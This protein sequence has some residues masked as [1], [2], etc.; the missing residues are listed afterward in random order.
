[1]IL[2]R[3]IGILRD[4]TIVNNQIEQ[5]KYFKYLGVTLHKQNNIHGE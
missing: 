3:K 5:I 1:M 2:T 4:I